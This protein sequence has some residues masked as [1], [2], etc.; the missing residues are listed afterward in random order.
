[1]ILSADAAEA[2]DDGEAEA[3]KKKPRRRRTRKAKA[4][5]DNDAQTEEAQSK[6]E[7]AVRM[8]KRKLLTM[9]CISEQAKSEI[10]EVIEEVIDRGRGKTEARTG[11]QAVES[12]LRKR[13][14]SD[15]QAKEDKADDA[16]GEDSDPNGDDAEPGTMAAIVEM[17]SKI[18]EDLP[19]ESG[20]SDETSGEEEPEA[21]EKPKPKRKT[22]SVASLLRQEPKRRMQ[23]N[24]EEEY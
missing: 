6:N 2:P 18:S 14:A 5:E 4:A 13:A 22:K 17:D 24:V 20:S 16:K 23:R 11:A 19:D 12:L 10:E 7:A 8:M 21:E 3:P 9:T 1:M 15:D